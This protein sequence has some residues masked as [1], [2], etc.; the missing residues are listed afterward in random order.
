MLPFIFEGSFYVSEELYLGVRFG[1]SRDLLSAMGNK[2]IDGAGEA[3][4]RL[5]FAEIHPTFSAAL[6][7]RRRIEQAIN[8]S[9]AFL[10]YDS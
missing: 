10:S 8:Y 6:R 1:T 5:L 9:A 2:K 3:V 4:R 7:R